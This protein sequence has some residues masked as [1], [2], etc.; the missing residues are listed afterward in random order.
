MTKIADWTLENLIIALAWLPLFWPWKKLPWLP[1]ICPP[2][3]LN[4]LA[5]PLPHIS[6]PWSLAMRRLIALKNHF[7]ESYFC[8]AWELEN[9]WKNR[10]KKIDPPWSIFSII[11]YSLQGAWI[12]LPGIYREAR[13]LRLTP[14]PRRPPGWEKFA[15]L[16]TR[17]RLPL[18]LDRKLYSISTRLLWKE[19]LL[20]VLWYFR[21]CAWVL[22]AFD[23]IYSEKPFFALSY[24]IIFCPPLWPAPPAGLIFDYLF[25]SGLTSNLSRHSFSVALCL[26]TPPLTLTIACHKSSSMPSMTA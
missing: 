7:F 2:D 18:T 6:W 5:L 12:W 1:F 15:R 10:E 19:K 24:E 11:W 23:M 3:A 20:R 14:P 21:A 22:C 16:A 9:L 17:P 8:H 25:W 26:T 13:L 4:R